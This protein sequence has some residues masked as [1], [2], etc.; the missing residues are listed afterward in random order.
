MLKSLGLYTSEKLIRDAGICH[1]YTTR[2][3]TVFI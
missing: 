1:H 2:N 3:N